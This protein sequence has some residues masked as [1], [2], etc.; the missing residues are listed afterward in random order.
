GAAGEVG[1][2][3]G[4]KDV[5]DWLTGEKCQLRTWGNRGELLVA[6]FKQ[7]AEQFPKP[8][9]INVT[10]QETARRVCA[11]RGVNLAD[12]DLLWQFALPHFDRVADVRTRAT[13]CEPPASGW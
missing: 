9:P 10:N 7:S 12:L 6:A 11:Q 4:V 8:D 1:K 5:R 2:P 3:G 13:G